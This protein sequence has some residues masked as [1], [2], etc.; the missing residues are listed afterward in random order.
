MEWGERVEYSGEEAGVSGD[1]PTLSTT[2]RAR[3]PRSR[4]SGRLPPP[5]TRSASLGFT[6]SRDPLTRRLLW[7]S[8]R[9]CRRNHMTLGRA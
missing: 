7:P 4:A 6:P 5:Y 9:A 1:A 3:D 8:A 2:T